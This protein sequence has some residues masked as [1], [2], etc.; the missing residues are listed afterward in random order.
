VGTAALDD[1]QWLLKPA[2]F[3]IEFCNVDIN[4]KYLNSLTPLS[5]AW[6]HFSNAVDHYL[7]SKEAS[8]Y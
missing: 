6:I 7:M 5:L 4:T 2:K 1:C 3:L 8:V